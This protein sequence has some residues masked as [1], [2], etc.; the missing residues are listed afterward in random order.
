MEWHEVIR[1]SL[2]VAMSVTEAMHRYSVPLLSSSMNQYRL[3]MLRCERQSELEPKTNFHFF[4]HKTFP[5]SYFSQNK[6]NTLIT[7]GSGGASL[8]GDATRLN[9]WKQFNKSTTNNK[10]S[11]RFW[12][13]GT[14]STLRWTCSSCCRWRWWWWR[15]WLKNWYK[16]WKEILFLL[17]DNCFSIR[18]WQTEKEIDIRGFK[19]IMAFWPN[20]DRLSSIMWCQCATNRNSQNKNK[21]QSKIDMFLSSHTHAM[22]RWAIWRDVQQQH[23]YFRFRFRLS[24][25]IH[26]FDRANERVLCSV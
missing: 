22:N 3:A 13:F 11:L 6:P 21:T 20:A 1:V 19:Y 2:A 5:G 7:E 8:D 18:S 15:W 16:V 25:W 9:H 10:S 12:W 14:L 24:Q 4:D 26:C 17:I 23:Y